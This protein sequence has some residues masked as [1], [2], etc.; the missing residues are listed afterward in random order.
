M[1]YKFKGTPTEFIDDIAHDF[2][3]TGSEIHISNMHNAGD[4]II[5]TDKHAMIIAPVKYLENEYT[6]VDKYPDWRSTLPKYEGHA[7]CTINVSH[8]I[9]K[10]MEA[11]LIDVKDVCKECDGE[12]VQECNFGHLC[13]FCY[14]KGVTGKTIGKSINYKLAIKL[15]NRAFYLKYMQNIAELAK[16]VNSETITMHDCY[17]SDSHCSAVFSVKDILINVM[18]VREYNDYIEIETITNKQQ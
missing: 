18:P 16:R 7:E 11:P 8:L 3:W 13:E 10:M 14:G 15:N 12:G 4:Y 6:P 2:L 17:N 9:D 1:E 5:A